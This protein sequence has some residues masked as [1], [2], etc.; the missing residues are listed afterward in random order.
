MVMYAATTMPHHFSNP[1]RDGM[2]N[3]DQI[4][5]QTTHIAPLSTK[6]HRS[7]HLLFLVNAERARAHVDQKEEPAAIVPS[8]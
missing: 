6:M 2:H 4:A 7:I 8:V 5:K 1:A 3:T